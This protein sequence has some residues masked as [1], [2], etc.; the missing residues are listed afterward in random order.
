MLCGVLGGVLSGVLGGLLS[1]F[2]M[3]EPVCEGT[4]RTGEQ[5]A[6]GST[7]SGT[8]SHRLELHPEKVASPVR[9]SNNNPVGPVTQQQRWPGLE[10]LLVSRS[11]ANSASVIGVWSG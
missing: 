2:V 1:G 7:Y 11:S 3:R 4:A 8:S 6:H 10:Y 5:H 9:A